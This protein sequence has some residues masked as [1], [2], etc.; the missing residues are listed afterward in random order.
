MVINLDPVIDQTVDALSIMESQFLEGGALGSEDNLWGSEAEKQQKIK[1]MKDNFK[2]RY[3]REA[4]K[5]RSELVERFGEKK[6][7]AVKHA[8]AF[9]L[10]EY[11]R[12]AS[13]EELAKLFP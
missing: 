12:Q 11:G 4:N 5:W 1:Q 13:R 10:C 2:R 9:E 7:K 8:I 3:T 6:G